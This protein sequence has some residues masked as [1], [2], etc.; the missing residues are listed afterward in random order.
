MAVNQIFTAILC[1]LYQGVYLVIVDQ[2][3]ML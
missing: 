3:E 1:F 2:S